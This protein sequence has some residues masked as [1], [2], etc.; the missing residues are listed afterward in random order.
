MRFVQ[1]M[2]HHWDMGLTYILDFLQ[3]PYFDIAT[4]VLN[5]FYAHLCKSYDCCVT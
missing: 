4:V 5:I 1:H 2:V 3:L